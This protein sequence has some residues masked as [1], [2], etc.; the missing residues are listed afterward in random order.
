MPGQSLGTRH[1]IMDPQFV[2]TTPA[3][4]VL[5]K[6]MGRLAAASDP[7]QILDG[8]LSTRNETIP[9]DSWRFTSLHTDKKQRALLD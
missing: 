4:D 9:G 3:G 1:V 6:D 8:T 7:K 5:S 2:A